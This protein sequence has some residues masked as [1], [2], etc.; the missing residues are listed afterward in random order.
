MRYFG[1]IR[2]PY[3]WLGVVQVAVGIGCAFAVLPLWRS[4]EPLFLRIFGCLLI[5]LGCVGAVFFNGI[6]NI[7]KTVKAN[8]YDYKN[9]G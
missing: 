6:P 1:F 7:V 4:D 3:F 2:F 9:N 8:Y 5:A